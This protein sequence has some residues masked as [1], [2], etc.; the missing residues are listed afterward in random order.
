MMSSKNSPTL[1]GIMPYLFVFTQ[2]RTE[3]YGEIAEPKRYTLFLE[4]L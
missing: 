1:F 4:L 2:F 3:G